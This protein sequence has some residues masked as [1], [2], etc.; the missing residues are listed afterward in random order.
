MKYFNMEISKM[1]EIL[2]MLNDGKAKFVHQEAEGYR[3]EEYDG[4]HG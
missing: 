2:F 4:I 3:L 1:Y